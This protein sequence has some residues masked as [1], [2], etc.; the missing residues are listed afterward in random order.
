[1]KEDEI[2]AVVKQSVHE[3][4]LALGID[5][6]EPIEV[7]R[8]FVYLRQSRKASQKISLT[9]RV[10]LIMMGVSALG[11]VLWLGIKSAISSQ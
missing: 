1:M 6:A 3:T 5:M 7:Q 10:G 4:L 9:V 2:Q 11:S 8:D